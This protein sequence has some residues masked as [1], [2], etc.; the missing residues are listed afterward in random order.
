MKQRLSQQKP[1]T[2]KTLLRNFLNRFAYELE[3]DEPVQGSDAVDAIRGLYEQA[4]RT[5]YTERQRTRRHR[6]Q[7]RTSR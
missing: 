3:N 5:P 2:A 1:L 4:K 6:S 7:S